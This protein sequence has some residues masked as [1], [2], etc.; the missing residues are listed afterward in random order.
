M[1]FISPFL[2]L[3]LI[4]LVAVL[5]VS[6]QFPAPVQ[7]LRL[8]VVENDSVQA[9]IGSKSAKGLML[10]VTDESGH[11]V[12][13]VAVALRLPDNG[14][15]GSF[16]DGTHAAVVYTDQ[17][18]CAHVAGIQW[19]N[20]PG[21]VA[22]RITAAK[23]AA[24]AGILVEQTL[25]ATA[26]AKPI[27]ISPPAIAVPAAVA[28]TLPAP[29]SAPAAPS[30]RSALPAQPGVIAARTPSPAAAAPSA[31]PA[32]SV[33][34]GSPEYHSHGGKAKWFIIAAIAIGAGA[35]IA[36]AAGKSKSSSSSS[37]STGV[38]IG[39]PSISIGHP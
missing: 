17:T 25:T 19:G 6:A 20:T 23:G 29:P 1:R 18:G 2:S 8:K 28:S 36:M 5:P 39:S 13:D 11:G 7:D 38:S 3:V 26:A 14:P 33:A 30:S 31:T 16:S 12:P 9:P 15:T 10:Q 22:L 35:G 21:V 4:P 34:N 37:S 32:V 24:H 27:S